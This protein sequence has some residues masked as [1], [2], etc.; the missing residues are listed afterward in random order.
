MASVRLITRPR[1]LAARPEAPIPRLKTPEQI[2]QLARAARAGKL[3]IGEPIE[4]ASN[5]TVKSKGRS[6]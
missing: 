5:G 3:A 2:D 4:I 1:F 6:R